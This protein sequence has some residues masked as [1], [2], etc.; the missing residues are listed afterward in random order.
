[1]WAHSVKMLLQQLTWGVLV[2][3]RDGYQQDRSQGDDP[4]GLECR[5]HDSVQGWL[6]ICLLPGGSLVLVNPTAGV[7]SISTSLASCCSAG[8]CSLPSSMEGGCSDTRLSLELPCP[9]QL[10]L[11]GSL[12]PGIV[13]SMFVQSSAVGSQQHKR[14]SGDAQGSI[15]TS[16]ALGTGARADVSQAHVWCA[17]GCP[18]SWS[19]LLVVPG[20]LWNRSSFYAQDVHALCLLTLAGCWSSFQS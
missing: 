19:I 1:M 5:P 17:Q 15:S 9:F 14:A 4:S 16:L 18:R 12:W 10:C 7:G 20:A 3:G 11:H 13:W 6:G 2:L 8:L